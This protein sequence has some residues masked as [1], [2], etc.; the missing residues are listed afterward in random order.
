M[1]FQFELNQL[2]TSVDREVVIGSLNVRSMIKFMQRR[3][4][5]TSATP[6]GFGFDDLTARAMASKLFGERIFNPQSTPSNTPGKGVGT[7]CRATA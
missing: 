4:Q 5:N 6:P 2:D 3:I 1:Y 7:M